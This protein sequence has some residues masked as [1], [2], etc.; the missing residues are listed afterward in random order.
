MC[1]WLEVLRVLRVPVEYSLTY[2][3]GGYYLVVMNNRVCNIDP[4]WLIPREHHWECFSDT[5]FA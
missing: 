2:G 4:P 5:R 3:L 1:S